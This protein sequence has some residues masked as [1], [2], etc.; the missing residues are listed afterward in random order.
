LFRALKERFRWREWALWPDGLDRHE[1]AALKLASR[2]LAGESS[3]Y[4]H[5]QFVAHRQ[6]EEVRT[7]IARRGVLLGG[8]L[9]FSPG[10]ESAE[11]WANQ[12]L[13]DLTRTVGAPPDAFSKDG[14]RW[15]LPMPDWARMRALDF[16]LIR[17][18]VRHAREI[19]DLLRIDHVVGLF[20]T[21]GFGIDPLAAGAFDPRAEADQRA[22]GDNILHVIKQDAKDMAIFAEDLGVVPPFVRTSLTAMGIPGYKV[23]RWEREW[24]VSGQPFIDPATYAELSVATTGTHDTD[25]MLEWWRAAGADERRQFVASLRLDGA[26]D[27]RQNELDDRAVDAI[28]ESLYMARSRIAIAPVQ[29]LF[30]WRDRINT[31]GT[32]NDANWKW[33]LPFALD[34]FADNSK[35]RQRTATLRAIASRTRRI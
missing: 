12:E 24:K 14:Q 15:G 35:V 25:T 32:M 22:Q 33:R 9:A 8:D 21:Y 2:E 19:F 11:V 27:A 16:S 1:P 23:M 34:S 7:E 5:I 28:I 26:I 18:R 10:R 6:W 30:G 17:A 31:P 13:F 3:F 4:S 20:R 29:D